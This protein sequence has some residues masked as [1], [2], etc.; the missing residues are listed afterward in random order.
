MRPGVFSLFLQVGRSSGFRLLR[1]V[2]AGEPHISGQDVKFV[3]WSSTLS[4]VQYFEACFKLFVFSA[5]FELCI[6][7]VTLAYK[8][9]L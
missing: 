2:K 8:T 4:T 1:E 3:F 6:R 5:A 9:L 7:N